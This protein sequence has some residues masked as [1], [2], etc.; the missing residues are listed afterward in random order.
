L[1]LHLSVCADNRGRGVDLDHRVGRV[2]LAGVGLLAD[3]E[4]VDLPL[5]RDAVDDVGGR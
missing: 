1:P 3:A 4:H 5:P 2:A